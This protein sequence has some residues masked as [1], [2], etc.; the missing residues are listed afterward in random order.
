MVTWTACG[1]D[2][3]RSEEHEQSER[4][5]LIFGSSRETWADEN[6]AWSFIRKAFATL[7]VLRKAVG[8][9]IDSKMQDSEAQ[10][11]NVWVPQRC[12]TIS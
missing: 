2:K 12:R 1:L 4:K 8:P 3:D 11:F 5:D 9:R 6:L 7:S 10:E